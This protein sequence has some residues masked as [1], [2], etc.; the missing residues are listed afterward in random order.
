LYSKRLLNVQTNHSRNCT[1]LVYLE[2][3]SNSSIYFQKKARVT[4]TLYV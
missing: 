3:C 4:K 2:V 1:I